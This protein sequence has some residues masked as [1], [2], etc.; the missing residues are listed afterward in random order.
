M[1]GGYDKPTIPGIASHCLDGLNAN[2]RYGPRSRPSSGQDVVIRAGRARRLTC[3]CSNSGRQR[4]PS[5][6]RRTSCA[7]L[8]HSPNHARMRGSGCRRSSTRRATSPRHGRR[9][10]RRTGKSSSTIGC[11]TSYR[12]RARCGNAT[13]KPQDRGGLPP[14]RAQLARPI[15]ARLGSSLQER[16][17]REESVADKGFFLEFQTLAQSSGCGG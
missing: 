13:R 17:R 5:S 11:S 1:G 6:W 8:R 7:M 9:R 14:Q 2:R 12:G 4:A 3:W 15:R 16:D 10:R